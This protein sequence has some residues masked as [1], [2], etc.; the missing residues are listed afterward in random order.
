MILQEEVLYIRRARF[1]A[2]LVTKNAIDFYRLVLRAQHD[3]AYRVAECGEAVLVFGVDVAL[4]V[5]ASVQVIG[6]FGK[7]PAAGLRSFQGVVEQTAVVGFEHHAAVRGKELF[8]T[9]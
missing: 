5:G 8:V 9:G 4:F 3:A 2:G 6:K 7:R 1:S